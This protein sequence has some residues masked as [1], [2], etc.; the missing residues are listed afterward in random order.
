MISEG[1]PRLSIVL[2]CYNEADSLPDLLA[3]YREVWEDLPA[4]LVLVDNG[5]TDE[6]ATVLERELSR[7]EY[8]FARVVRV[9][10]NRGY[11]HG[12]A[13]G[14][15]AARGEY[16]SWS[17][18]DMQCSPADPFRAYHESMRAPDPDRIV[19]KGLRTNPRGIA[20]KLITVGMSVIASTVLAASLSDI[21]AQPKVFKRD[22]LTFLSDPPDGFQF[23]LYVL[24]IAR[25]QGYGIRTIPVHF[26]ERIHGESRWAATFRSRFRTIMAT[27]RYIFRLRFSSRA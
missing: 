21:N 14:L 18:A 8:S 7:P 25:R 15:S 20:A 11:G 10:R 9:K 1:A 23:D 13:A 5:S 22:L 3:S 27:I 2:P 12:I 17:H 4:E 6:T 26:G 24:Y 19:V 16:L